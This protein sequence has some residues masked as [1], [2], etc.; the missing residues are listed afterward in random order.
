[1]STCVYVA[2]DATF[3]HNPAWWD[4]SV[5]C[6]DCFITS[7]K[8]PSCSEHHYGIADLLQDHYNCLHGDV[9]WEFTP[10]GVPSAG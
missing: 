9:T 3:C 8:Y 4:V 6:P 1:M 5:S 7:A 10:H 2:E